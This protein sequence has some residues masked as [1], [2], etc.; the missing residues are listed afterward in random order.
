MGNRNSGRRPVP[1]ALK[2]LRGT[3]QKSRM[4]LRE[5]R[6]PA[7]VPEMP[8]TLSEGARR[9]WEGMAPKCLHMGVLTVV[10]VEAF[11]TLC[12]LEAKKL[13]AAQ[14]EDPMPYLRLAEKIRQY[15]GDFGLTPASRS[16]IQVRKSDE[17]V[18][19]W[20]GKLA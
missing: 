19:K 1:T 18:S 6:P 7:G 4:N 2:I 16:R 10:D 17:P 5:P 14:A 9:V 20:S 11:A 12:E 8:A 13:A 15:Y 3:T